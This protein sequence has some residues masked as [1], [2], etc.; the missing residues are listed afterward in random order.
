MTALPLL[1]PG[2][3]GVRWVHRGL[4]VE[5]SRPAFPWRRR[6]TF[7]ISPVLLRNP[8]CDDQVR[9]TRDPNT[10]C[11]ITANHTDSV[12]LHAGRG[13]D[14]VPRLSRRYLP[15]RLG[16]ELERGDLETRR[17]GNRELRLSESAHRGIPI[18]SWCQNAA[19]SM[20]VPSICRWPCAFRLEVTPSLGPHDDLV[21]TDLAEGWQNPYPAA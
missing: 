12:A 5:I 1:A 10:P 13:G 17:S 15:G 11:V 9:R 7:S 2:R 4:R 21:S 19:R 18:I 8:A 14:A 16:T 6:A 3:E 20:N